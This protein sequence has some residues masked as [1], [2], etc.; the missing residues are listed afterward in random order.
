MPELK[1]PAWITVLGFAAGVMLM[2]AG[3]RLKTGPL[4][5]ALIDAVLA[6]SWFVWSLRLALFP[7]K[8]GR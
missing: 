2:C 1:N 7:N 8:G 5:Y 6:A 4:S 3:M